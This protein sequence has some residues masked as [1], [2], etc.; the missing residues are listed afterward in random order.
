[1]APP[2]R[3]GMMNPRI[4]QPLCLLGAALVLLCF[5]SGHAHSEDA[6]GCHCFRN[7]SYD[8]GDKFAVDDYLRAT[9]VNSLVS[10]YFGVSKRDIVMMRMNGV[11]L[12]ELLTAFYI[13]KA[14]RMDHREILKLRS[15]SLPWAEVVIRAGLDPESVEPGFGRIL[16]RGDRHVVEHLEDATLAY[17]FSTEPAEIIELRMLGLD[18]VRDRVL[19]LGLARKLGLSSRNLARA[20]KEEN[21]SWGEIA[22]G[23]GLVPEHMGSYIESLG[24]G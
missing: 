12:E 10:R 16:D 14:G 7:R 22:A 15:A 20:L 19:A 18:N 3:H 1:M 24:Q 17:F 5:I 8:P 6:A 13:G 11:P 2:S 4:L 9:A 23:A 21:R